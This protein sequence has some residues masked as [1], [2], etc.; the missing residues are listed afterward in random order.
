MAADSSENDPLLPKSENRSGSNGDDGSVAGSATNGGPA[1]A[2]PPPPSSPTPG[3]SSSS[4]GKS[5]AFSPA[6]GNATFASQPLTSKTQNATASGL[7]SNS[8]SNGNNNNNSAIIVGG[9]NANDNAAGSAAT[10]VLA[11]FNT[12][13][14]RRHSSGGN[15]LPEAVISAATPKVGPQRTTKKTQKLKLL[16]NP[17]R[18]DEEEEGLIEDG[19]P[20]D[21][22]SQIRRI[23][24]P[25]ARRDAARLGKSDRERLPRVTAYCTASAYALEAVV[26]FL[27]SRAST[28]GAAPRLF[29]ECVY[30]PYKYNYDKGKNRASASGSSNGRQ[31]QHHHHHR[32]GSTGGSGNGNADGALLERRYSDSEIEVEDHRKQHREDLI[33]L[34]DEQ[35]ENP[36]ITHDV[37][38]EVATHM[39]APDAPVLD[40]T[41]ETPEIF[42]FDYGTVV[43]WGMTPTE[44]TRFLNEV[45]KFA[46]SVLGESDMQVE[47]FN[48]YYTRDYQARIYNDFIS[49][50][51]PKNYMI[52][53]AIS[54]AL[55]QSVKTS[56]FE[57]LVDES[58]ETTAPLPAQIAETGSVH[59]TR[60]Q[61][62]MQIGELFILRINIHLQGS[63]LDA[64]ELMWAE[65]HLDP[66]YQAVRSY[67]EMDQRVGLLT[68]R[69]EVISD[70]LAV[71]KDQL[72]HRHDEYLE[73]IVIVLIAAEIVVAAINIVVD[74]YAGE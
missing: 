43:I 49:L 38:G 7:G 37:S 39:E 27:K 12:R 5:V 32:G 6:Q 57:D 46:E 70:L 29:D 61:I 17:E 68:E 26:R 31:Q 71:L 64:P 41:V 66:V 51:D 45:S 67:L 15:A 55:A 14:R 44:E 25:T 20:Q 60:R 73:W 21:V 16:P 72:T 33:S 62:N 42:L 48:F 58:I 63:V 69:L 24:E 19:I 74:L 56:L 54:H 23:K 3:P 10:P 52:K 47:N 4:Y 9:A 1:T 11:A 59:L 35:P 36:P 65:P 18:E 40:T 28:R 30:S 50:R 53:L 2:A 13:L 34:E 22:Y 8:N